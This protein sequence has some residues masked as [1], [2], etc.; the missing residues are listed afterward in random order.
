MS[1]LQEYLEK[2]R[3]EIRQEM[4]PLEASAADLRGKLGAVDTK[5]RTMTKEINEIEKALQAIAKKDKLQTK[6]TIKEA[7]L[8]ILATAP[9]GMHATEILTTLN[10]RFFDTMLRRTSLSPQLT[11]LK[12]DD[13]KIKFRG[14]KY[15]LA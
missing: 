11:R 14:G 4:G 12:N 2:R 10:D 13:H 15:F 6:I 5:L 9:N 8:Q 7:I 3:A 1:R